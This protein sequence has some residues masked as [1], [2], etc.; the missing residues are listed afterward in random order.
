MRFTI[1]E[2]KAASKDMING[3]IYY[4]VNVATHKGRKN[5]HEAFIS[6]TKLV[7]EALKIYVALLRP[8]IASDKS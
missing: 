2:M 8:L 5:K 3:E 4:T 7:Y 6:F 1:E